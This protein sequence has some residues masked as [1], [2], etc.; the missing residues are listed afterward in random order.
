MPISAT[1]AAAGPRSCL[2]WSMAVVVSGQMVVH[3][4]S[5]NE[6]TTTLPR[7]ERNETRSPNWSVSLK[8]GATALSR[9][10]GSRFGFATDGVCVSATG[11]EG[12]VEEPAT[13][14]TAP[15]PTPMASAIP[16]TVQCSRRD[17]TSSMASR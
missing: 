9:A 5:L 8:L 3:S 6:R 15:M 10:P 16:N 1:L 4:G 7:S 14:I 11:V 13:A 12:V 17:T 2:A